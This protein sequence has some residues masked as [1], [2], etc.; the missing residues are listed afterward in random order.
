MKKVYSILIIM[1]IL[2][3]FSVNQAFASTKTENELNQEKMLAELDNFEE[4]QDKNSL[5]ELKSKFDEFSTTL[6]IDNNL[7]KY[8]NAKAYNVKESNIKALTIPVTDG[9]NYN[10]ISNISVYF[11]SNGEVLHYTELYV[12]K[13]DKGTFEIE[14]LL[15]GKVQAQKITDEKFTTAKEYQEKHG[16]EIQPMGVNWDNFLECM[17]ITG[18]AAGFISSVCGFACALTAGT[19]CIVCAAGVLGF[20]SGAIGGCLA[21]S[22]E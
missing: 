12:S 10:E 13:S 20:N 16:G 18:I 15:N 21:G 7:F 9:E 22:W 3:S 19:A 4:I 17:G 6:E 14:L 11:D 5:D 8:D 1:A 2:L